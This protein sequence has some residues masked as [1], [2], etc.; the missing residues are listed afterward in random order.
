VRANVNSNNSW[1]LTCFAK[2][3]NSMVIG[4]TLAVNQQ[5]TTFFLVIIFHREYSCRNAW[6]N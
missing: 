3:K 5:F 4:L 2:S 6:F 1:R